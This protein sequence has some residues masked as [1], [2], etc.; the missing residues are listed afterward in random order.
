MQTATNPIL[1]NLLTPWLAFLLLALFMAAFNGAKT[2]SLEIFSF[3]SDFS[4]EY[5]RNALAHQENSGFG[6]RGA[7]DCP[8]H[9]SNKRR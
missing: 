7:S 5:T 9:M 8:V 6:Y 3:S 1:R 4:P 2:A